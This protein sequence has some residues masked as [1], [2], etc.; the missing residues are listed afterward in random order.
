MATII[1]PAD[2]Q[3]K[4][5]TTLST[6]SMKRYSNWY[7]KYVKKND[8]YDIQDI[9][10]FKDSIDDEMRQKKDYTSILSVLIK[11]LNVHTETDN[12]TVLV[13]ETLQTLKTELQQAKNSKDVIVK[14]TENDTKNQITVEEIQEIKDKKEKL[15][16]EK[17]TLNNA[18]HL[19]FLKFITLLPPLRT[20]DYINTSFRDMDDVNFMDLEN[21]LFIIKGGKVA[22]SKRT[23]EM[24]D[25][26]ITFITEL[27]EK[28]KS[29][30]LFPKIKNV[31]EPMTTEGVG[32]WLNRMFG[33][34]VSTSRLRNVF[35]SHWKDTNMPKEQRVKNS[36]IMG[37]SYQMSETNYT[38]Y[39]EALHEKDRLI[40]TLQRENEE[41]KKKLQDMENKQS[42]EIYNITINYNNA[43]QESS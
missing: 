34:A 13:N 26:L 2:I 40:E 7:K 4:L 14:P 39:S 43:S 22:N 9:V 31:A 36:A 16:G 41:L 38:K 15:Y 35:V 5:L 32:K 25:E 12:S 27:K 28:F 11:L 29:E 1:F 20:Q 19:Q 24:P 23:I 21:K 30:W 33:K 3:T 8:I 17:P 37:H 18:Y 10:N 6:S 42:T